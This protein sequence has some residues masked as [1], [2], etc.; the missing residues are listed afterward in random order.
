MEEVNELED[1]VFES[2]EGERETKHKIQN[3]QK[4]SSKLNM[5]FI[6]NQNNNYTSK[7]G[8]KNNSSILAIWNHIN[9]NPNYGSKENKE[10]K[11]E[12]YFFYHKKLLLGDDSEWDLE[13]EL[14]IMEE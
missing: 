9:N 14:E 4:S 11:E 2:S 3:K 12:D 13:A 10:V 7:K 5:N 8:E 1:E 6:I